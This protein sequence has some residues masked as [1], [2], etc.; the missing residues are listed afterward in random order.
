[1][2]KPD[3]FHPFVVQGHDEQDQYL[4]ELKFES[5]Q[6][7]MYVKIGPLEIHIIQTDCM[8]GVIIEAFDSKTVEQELASAQIFYEDIETDQENEH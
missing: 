4:P 8:L 1:M 3:N 7:R 2:N 5:P 6:G